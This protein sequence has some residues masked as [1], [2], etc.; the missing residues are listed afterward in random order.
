MG[1][2]TSGWKR[3]R[4]PLI[5]GTSSV[6]IIV[7][8]GIIGMQVTGVLPAAKRYN[9][10]VEEA[11]AFGIPTTAQELDARIQPPG[12][13]AFPIVSQQLKVVDL[14]I[15]ND[16]FYPFDPVKDD[17][18]KPWD[19]RAKAAYER[20]KAAIAELEKL[21]VQNAFRR[22]V[23]PSRIPE[24]PIHDRTM[25]ALECYASSLALH[26]EELE[27][28][29]LYRL[30]ALLNKWK[31]SGAVSFR[32]LALREDVKLVDRLSALATLKKDSREL[33]LAVVDVCK[34]ATADPVDFR[35]VYWN[36]L[37]M[38]VTPLDQDSGPLQLSMVKTDYGRAELAFHLPY[39]TRA[40]QSDLL[41]A[42][43]EGYKIVEKDPA[44]GTAYTDSIT[45]VQSE[46]AKGN[47]LTMAIMR[48]LA[49]LDFAKGAGTLYQSLASTKAR[50]E[51][52]VE[53]WNAKK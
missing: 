34:I 38:F 14:A 53:G 13:D 39:V 5:V 48:E 41:R 51:K 9:S 16:R 24:Q 26:G 1:E 8:L 17:P 19:A 36:Q 29:K 18:T 42:Y 37:V 31:E 45:K 47:S 2:R 20:S 11:K 3:W 46:I 50:F 25:A 22:P 43:L 30:L 32:V 27:A 52:E 15:G 4:R 49:P 40:T 12:P 33:P 7:C 28:R 23:G 44:S 35:R 21:S 6:G 10:L